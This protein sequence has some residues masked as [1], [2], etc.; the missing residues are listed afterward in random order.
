MCS[1]ATKGRHV[2]SLSRAALTSGIA[3]A[4]SGLGMAHG[5]AAALGVHCRVPHGLACAVMLPV[6]MRTNRPVCENDLAA[7]ASPLT[8]RTFSD[9]SVA[10]SA[11]I[12]AIEALCRN[13]GIPQRLG[14]IG[15]TADQ[16]DALVTSSRGSSMSGNPRV[17]SDAELRGILEAML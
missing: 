13:V 7:L 16:L 11:S 15:V 14:E 10:A 3:L 4:N 8:G 17:L 5:I 1:D 9:T 6:A 2:R 12:E